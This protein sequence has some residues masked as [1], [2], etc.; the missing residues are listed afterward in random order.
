MVIFMRVS[1]FCFFVSL[2]ATFVCLAETPTPRAHRP[3]DTPPAL[4]MLVPGFTVRTLPVE[5]PNLVNLQYRHDGVLV[6]LGYNG[7]IWLLRDSNGFIH[8]VQG[9]PAAG[10][11]LTAG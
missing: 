5:L 8:E 3:K 10:N 2:A 1:G 7:N 9:S 6:A 11:R 4:Q